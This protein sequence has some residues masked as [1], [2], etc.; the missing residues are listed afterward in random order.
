L[1]DQTMKTVV[2]TAITAAALISISACG[3]N[4]THAADP[5]AAYLDDVNAYLKSHG[6]QYPAGTPQG[7]L[8][9][10]AL[11]AGRHVCDQAARGKSPDEILAGMQPDPN[12]VAIG[13]ARNTIAAAETYL[14]PQYKH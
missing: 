9:Q 3:G 8:D 14:C 6:V 4:T 13:T 10:G 11:L 1:K 2:A 12:V 5:T 7:P